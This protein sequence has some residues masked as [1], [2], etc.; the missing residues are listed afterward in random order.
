M[1]FG[2][3]ALDDE[4]FVLETLAGLN[5][6]ITTNDWNEQRETDSYAW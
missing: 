3:V 5:N 1:F 4:P 2:L 6:N